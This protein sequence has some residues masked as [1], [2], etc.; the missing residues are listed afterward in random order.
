MMAKDYDRN[1][2]VALKQNPSMT[3]LL[4]DPKNVE[5][6]NNAVKLFK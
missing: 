6:S 1:K 3:K 2:R 5:D 4:L